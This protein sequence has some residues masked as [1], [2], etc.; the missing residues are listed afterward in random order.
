MDGFD[1]DFNEYH[2]RMLAAGA[3]VSA[4]SGWHEIHYRG[5]QALDEADEAAARLLRLWELAG[6]T[7]GA[8]TAVATFA[9]DIARSA[10]FALDAEVHGPY[11]FTG[12]PVPPGCGHPQVS[13]WMHRLVVLELDRWE[14][15]R[16][17]LAGTPDRDRD[18]DPVGGSSWCHTCHD[19]HRLADGCP[20]EASG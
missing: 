18:G 4:A 9:L 7:P 1:F 3:V 16:R 17:A 13:E 11:K 10:L 19:W 2:D 15:G 8:V 12:A 14:S 5:T 20:E 6:D